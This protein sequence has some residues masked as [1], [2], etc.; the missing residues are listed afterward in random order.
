MPRLREEVYA[1]EYCQA[2]IDRVWH[3]ADWRESLSP[4]PPFYLVAEKADYGPPIY[5]IPQDFV[6]LRSATLRI[7]FDGDGKITSTTKPLIIKTRQAGFTRF[8]EPE[9]LSYEPSIQTLRVFPVL[10]NGTL[11]NQFIVEGVYKTLPKTNLLDT[12]LGVGAVI[13]ASQITRENYTKCL[14]PLDDRHYS[15]MQKVM[16]SIV[17]QP[18]N[19]SEEIGTQQY[20][21]QLL[22]GVAAQEGVDIGS[23]GIAP[24][25]SLST[26]PLIQY[27]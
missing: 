4:L 6:G 20:I 15:M 1:A 24:E 17:K 10:G 19:L 21:D 16:K 9:V 25:E 5:A 11:P 26:E 23:G 27:W 7:I 3:F 13:L 22:L 18:A 12:A 14:L 8:G 2:L